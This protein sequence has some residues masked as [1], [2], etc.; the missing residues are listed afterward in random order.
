MLVVLELSGQGMSELHSQFGIAYS[1]DSYNIA[2]SLTQG[3]YEGLEVVLCFAVSALEL[4]FPLPSIYDS[5]VYSL[6]S[7]SSATNN[8][9]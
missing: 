5:A 2:Y 9:A 8:E 3:G 7:F 6:R 4:D 1:R